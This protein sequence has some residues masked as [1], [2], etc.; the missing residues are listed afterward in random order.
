[1]NT[2]LIATLLAQL[3]A[4]PS[5]LKAL[6]D[7][8]SQRDFRWW[9][10][11]VFLILISAGVVVYKLLITQLSQQRQ[12]NTDLNNKLLTY[13][14]TD[15]GKL[16]EAITKVTAVLERIEE[17]SR[18]TAITARKL[19]RQLSPSPSELENHES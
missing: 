8:L 15:R 6:A 13:M 5:K 1:M 18:I 4:D 9:F 16:L 2:Y 3:P 11:A 19:S 10:A 17:D 7:E 14:D 12:A